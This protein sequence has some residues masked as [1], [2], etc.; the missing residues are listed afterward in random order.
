MVIQVCWWDTRTVVVA[1][2]LLIFCLLLLSLLLVVFMVIQVCWWDTRAG[3]KPQ[4][5]VSLHNSHIEPVYKVSSDNNGDD[6]GD[7]GDYDDDRD[8]I[9]MISRQCGSQVRLSASS[10]RPLLMAP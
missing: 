4:A 8:L 5:E 9:F 10:S 7:H 3:G 1:C 6:H 2:L